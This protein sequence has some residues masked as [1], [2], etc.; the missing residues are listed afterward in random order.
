MEKERRGKQGR[1]F[2]LRDNRKG[3]SE[4]V[5][6][7]III[8][9]VIIAVGIIWTVVRN[10]LQ[11]GADQIEISTKCNNVDIKA[12]SV[13]PAGM[14]GNYTVRLSRGGDAEDP[15][16]GIMIT[17]YNN[18]TNSPS[19]VDFGSTL[20]ALQDKTQEVNSTLVLQIGTS[21][22]T[23]VNKETMGNATKI[24]YT[25]YFLS[26][27]GDVQLCPGWTRTYEF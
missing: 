17:F 13:S 12:V 26:S 4:I 3:L 24:T 25:P 11:S 7:L 19:A 21:G 18:E 14:P 16:E 8:L 27:A 23:F 6:T 15:V 1:D 9:L 5:A 20:S 22:V 2:F 10:L